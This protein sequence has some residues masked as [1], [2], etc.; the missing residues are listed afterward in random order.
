MPVA[1]GKAA[2][3]HPLG[4]EADHFDQPI[5]SMALAADRQGAAGQGQWHDPEIDIGG[6][7]AIEPHLGF[8]IALPGFDGRKID[9][10]TAQR[11]FEFVDV[12]IGEKHPREMRFDY[13]DPWRL[14]CVGQWR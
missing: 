13:F 11:F 14:V 4:G 12:L 9:A 5:D 7:P 3:Q 6:E 2:V 1:A 10:V 8:G